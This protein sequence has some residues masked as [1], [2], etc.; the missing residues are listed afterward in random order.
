VA[1]LYFGL[2]S[3]QRDALAVLI[4]RKAAVQKQFEQ[5]RL[6]LAGAKQ[7]QD[8]LAETGLKVSHI[9][10]TMA[11]GDLYSWAI[12]T[13]R[14]F[15]SGYKQIEIPQFSQ[16]DG[17]K[18]CDLLPHFPYKQA[19]MS[20]AGKAFYYDFGKFVADFEN[21]FPHMRLLNL[22]LQPSSSP[23]DVEKLSFNMEIVMLV[24]PSNS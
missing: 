4:A 8:A 21:Q 17:P 23:G 12:N 14:Q 7:V 22:S 5:V 6:T 16:I 24:K 19:R 10:Q 3:S 15:K 18:D 11:S 13:L 20:I 2:I 9:E 1:G